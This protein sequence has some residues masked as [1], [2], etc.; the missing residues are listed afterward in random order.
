MPR[1]S[2]CVGPPWR[3]V[4]RLSISLGCLA[5]VASSQVPMMSA[6]Q[7]SPSQQAVLAKYC[8][9]CHT[10][11]VH[12]A[13]LLLNKASI[14]DVSASADVWEKVVHKLRTG[15]MPP[16]GLPRP[17]KA[18]LDT[19]VTRLETSLDQAAAAKP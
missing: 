8:F 14:E 16:P 11:R 17:D 10:E 1:H 18:T 15:E 5:S 13:G 2:K 3:I 6:S 4:A 12:A 9:T 19:F 7:A